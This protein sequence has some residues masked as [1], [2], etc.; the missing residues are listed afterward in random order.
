MV[1]IIMA[2]LF[3]SALRVRVRETRKTITAASRTDTAPDRMAKVIF[4]R[5]FSPAAFSK[6]EPAGY[7]LLR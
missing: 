2:S 6:T 3:P 4:P 1:P 7:C 5:L